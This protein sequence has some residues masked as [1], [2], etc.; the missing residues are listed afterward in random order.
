MVNLWLLYALL[1]AFFAALVAIFGKI[2][3]KNLDSNSATFFRS[4]VMTLFLFL[5]VF[6]QGKLKNLAYFF[7]NSKPLLFIILGGIAGALSW[8]FYFLALK[9]TDVSKIV[10]IDRLSVVFAL[11]LA[12]LF[13]GEKVNLMTWLGAILI[14]VGGIIIALQ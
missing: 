4:V 14:V 7:E 1:S 11:V 3:L 8:L 10:P 9:A 6:F 5:V 13:L 12:F 2:G